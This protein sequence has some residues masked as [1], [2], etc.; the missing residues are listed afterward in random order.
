V[1]HSHATEVEIVLGTINGRRCLRISDNGEG[2]PKKQRTGMGLQVL[3]HRARVI[4]AE[5]DVRSEPGKGVMI[6]CTL[7]GT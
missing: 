7:V 6:T 5:L 4:G 1:K 3:Q 2:F